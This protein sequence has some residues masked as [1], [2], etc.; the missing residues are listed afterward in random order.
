MYV[1]KCWCDSTQVAQMHHTSRKVLKTK[2]AMPATN[3]DKSSNYVMGSL[4][5]YVQ[6]TLIIKIFSNYIWSVVWNNK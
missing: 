5:C 4:T 6:D 3:E 1:T 2:H